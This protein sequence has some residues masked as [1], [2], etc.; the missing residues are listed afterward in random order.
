MC[1]G[2]YS[3][4]IAQ[5]E[6][7]LYGFNKYKNETLS[8]ALT[9]I[10][11]NYIE[12]NI[13]T[14]ESVYFAGGEPLINEAHYR[15]LE[16]LIENKK[17]KV[18]ISYNTN[19]SILKYKKYNLID[20]WSNFDSITIGAS[21]DL[22]GNQSNYVR[23]GAEY[24]TIEENYK[25]VKDIP[26]IKFKLTSIVHLMNIYNLPKLQKRWLDLGMD[27]GNISF[28]I[29]TTPAEQSITVLPEH[30][31]NIALVTIHNHLDY[32]STIDNSESLIEEWK[33]ART[34]MTSKSDTHLLG[35]FFRLTDDKDLARKQTF[36]DYFPEFKDLR[37]YV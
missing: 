19:F 34:F 5:E 10:Q 32:L 13:N 31:K 15:I 11:L 22:I 1:S 4:R 12:K 21:I 2:K 20:L 6:E 23:H 3:N 24:S 36:E 9:E 18:D 28:N 14:I 27:C 17:T 33:R 29:L 25:I 35:E 26:N 37:N 8:P 7:K 30:Y 16:L